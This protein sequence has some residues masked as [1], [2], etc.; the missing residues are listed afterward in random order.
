M[1]LEE[2]AATGL[3]LA[4][5]ERLQVR[6]RRGGERCRPRGRPGGSASLKKLLQEWGVPPWWRDRLPLL[7]LDE[8]LLAVGGLWLCESSRLADRA[9]PGRS[10]WRPR[11]WRNI[12]P[13]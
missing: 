7:Y 2:A 13:L 9:E 10:L 6:W 3:S 12:P 8:E 4:P 5:G 1:A 11:W